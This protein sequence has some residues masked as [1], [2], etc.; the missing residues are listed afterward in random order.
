MVLRDTPDVLLRRLGSVLLLGDLNPTSLGTPSP[1]SRHNVHSWCVDLNAVRWGPQSQFGV[2]KRRTS[3]QACQQ[4]VWVWRKPLPHA[5]DGQYY[6]QASRLWFCWSSGCS[7]PASRLRLLRCGFYSW[8][9]EKWYAT[10][11]NGA[12]FRSEE[13]LR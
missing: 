3:F 13:R 12:T 4:D 6:P 10:R 11:C 8:P 7:S 5:G 9:E 1:S 2:P